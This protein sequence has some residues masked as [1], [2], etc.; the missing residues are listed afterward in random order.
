MAAILRQTPPTHPFFPSSS[1]HHSSNS[2]PQYLFPATSS[3]LQNFLKFESMARLSS[4]PTRT[5]SFLTRETLFWNCVLLTRLIRWS[6]QILNSA[7]LKQ[8]HKFHIH[9]H[10]QVYPCERKKNPASKLCQK[11]SEENANGNASISKEEK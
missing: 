10:A 2:V 4:F 5:E 9:F 7:Q 3:L 11:F 8:T 1:S 6:K